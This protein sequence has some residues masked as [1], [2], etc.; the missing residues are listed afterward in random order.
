MFQKKQ[1]II[2]LAI[3]FNLIFINGNLIDTDYSRSFKPFL[4]TKN[5]I[6]NIIKDPKTEQI[7]VIGEYQ[8]QP[9][10]VDK[11]FTG[12]NFYTLAPKTT[13]PNFVY[14]NSSKTTPTP[15]PTPTPKGKSKS[16]TKPIDS[17]LTESDELLTGSKKNYFKVVKASIYN[18]CV[19]YIGKG[20]QDGNTFI[21]MYNLNNVSEYFQV[22]S[23][24]SYLSLSVDDTFIWATYK[25]GNQ[26]YLKPI[27]HDG[28]KKIVHKNDPYVPM[29]V[30]ITNPEAVISQPITS[31]T[32][33]I[34]IYDSAAHVLVKFSHSSSLK[35]FYETEGGRLNVLDACSVRLYRY[36]PEKRNTY[37]MV[38]KKDGF[39]LYNERS[40]KSISLTSGD[41]T[42]N[43]CAPFA[44]KG[45]DTFYATPGS[46]ELSRTIPG[47]SFE[48]TH[49]CYGDKGTGEIKIIAPQDVFQFKWEDQLS[50]TKSLIRKNL[51]DG[52][53]ILQYWLNGIDDPINMVR[54][55]ISIITPDNP[56]F[57]NVTHAC[58]NAAQGVFNFTNPKH[59]DFSYEYILYSED[60]KK[61][62]ILKDGSVF[63]GL[64]GDRN[65][66]VN[67]TTTTKDIFKH[68]CFYS[69]KE[70]LP[71]DKAEKPIIEYTN[72]TCADSKD[73]RIKI[74]N[75]KPE[76]YNYIVTP[77]KYNITSE[78][79]IEN[80]SDLN[81]VIK[82]EIKGGICS[83]LVS[84]DIYSP[85]SAK[86]VKEKLKPKVIKP[87]CYGSKGSIKVAS[88]DGID[89]E[90]TDSTGKV[91]QPIINKIRT[92]EFNGL[93]A[94]KY[95][96]EAKIKSTRGSN[97]YCGSVPNNLTLAQ[98]KRIQITDTFIE[99]IDCTRAN[100]ANMTITASGGTQYNGSYYDFSL[101]SGALSHGHYLNVSYWV[102]GIYSLNI[103]DS[104]GCVA[105]YNNI[106]IKRPSKC[107]VH[108]I[109]GI[110]P[111]GQNPNSIQNGGGS[112]HGNSKKDDKNKL[113]L[114]LGLCLGIGIPFII[115]ATVLT[116]VLVKKFG[117]RFARTPSMR[118]QPRPNTVPVFMGG[119]IHNIDNF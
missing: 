65:Y 60:G 24:H 50:A 51:S 107:Q 73:A 52:D 32:R 109:N 88:M 113:G 63:P 10:E 104:K 39:T 111:Q 110:H 89:F 17:S 93:T 37:W 96:L 90:L 61:P 2:F 25:E 48:V 94:D 27:V 62:V 75:F 15:T 28:C 46:D 105:T 103:S 23:S 4:E 112:G 97:M 114:I 35:E 58:V 34:Y 30:N 40:E 49:P 102:D 5:K 79:T 108:N 76:K 18:G 99:S 47:I 116:V 84:V 53:Y 3:L 64:Y 82:A 20:L 42:T 44:T 91:H 70:F 85:P 8:T 106:T 6:G 7:Y 43:Y 55:N 59:P 21:A 86:V 11:T 36:D 1:L 74:V 101:S 66:T 80:V 100:L 16:T 98:P 9:E 77:S 69:V 115:L 31:S 14:E 68:Q 92:L 56:M 29:K 12:N 22:D 33:F 19:A 118:N 45:L 41:D 78:G 87:P 38:S 117:H 81:I 13:I 83:Q 67:I 72:L 95:I 71:N 54:K 119:K 26:V 57:I